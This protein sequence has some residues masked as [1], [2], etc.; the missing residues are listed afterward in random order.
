LGTI[1][2]FE[3]SWASLAGGHSQLVTA[4]ALE[5]VASAASVGASESGCAIGVRPEKMVVSRHATNLP[6]DF[7]GTIEGLSY[8]GNLS[9]ATIRLSQHR[10]VETTIVNSDHTA[11]R[12]QYRRRRARRISCRCRGGSPA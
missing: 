10:L 9:H 6:N 3:G 12:T 4:D 5:I 7:S 11:R 2:L 1:N 8:C